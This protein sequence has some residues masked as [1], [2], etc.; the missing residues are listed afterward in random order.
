VLAEKVWDS[1]LGAS[2]LVIKAG[3]ATG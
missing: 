1:K 2:V 3:A